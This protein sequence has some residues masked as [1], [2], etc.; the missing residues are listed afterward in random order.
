[1][2]EFYKLEIAG[3]YIA[4]FVVMRDKQIRGMVSVLVLANELT[5][6]L[7]YFIG[8]L[9]KFSVVEHC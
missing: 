3:S 8:T 1:M 9:D 2:S 6:Q 4:V 5:Y 7:V